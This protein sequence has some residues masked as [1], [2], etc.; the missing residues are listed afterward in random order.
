M[1]FGLPIPISEVMLQHKQECIIYDYK[2]T[3]SSRHFRLKKNTND[4]Q[5]CKIKKQD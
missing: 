3:D 4:G 5:D 1:F 2:G